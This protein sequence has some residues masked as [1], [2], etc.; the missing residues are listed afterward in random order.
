LL[1]EIS[2]SSKIAPTVMVNCS[3]D[4][5]HFHTWTIWASQAAEKGQRSSESCRKN[6][7]GAKARTYF[8]QVTARLK[9]CPEKKPLSDEVANG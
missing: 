3:R 2:L 7:A 6:P 8:E 4:P 1:K 5:A 9:S